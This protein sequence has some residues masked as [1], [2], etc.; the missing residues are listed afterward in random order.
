MIDFR[1]FAAAADLFLCGGGE[2]KITE[3]GAHDTSEQ[4]YAHQSF[5]LGVDGQEEEENDEK[6]YQFHQVQ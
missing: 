6:C 1:E 4:T 2:D 5:D 3:E